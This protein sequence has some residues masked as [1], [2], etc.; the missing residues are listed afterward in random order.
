MREDGE[1]GTPSP[2]LLGELIGGGVALELVVLEPVLEKLKV[3]T[4]RGNWLSQN[5]V[6]GSIPSPV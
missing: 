6:P 2:A 5:T 3:R 1:E 4:R